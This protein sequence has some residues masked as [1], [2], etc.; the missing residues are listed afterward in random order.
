MPVGVVGYN[1]SQCGLGHSHLSFLHL[2]RVCIVVTGHH[3]KSQKLDMFPGHEAMM[4][5]LDR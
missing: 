4:F 3:Y 1:S 2:H 5:G